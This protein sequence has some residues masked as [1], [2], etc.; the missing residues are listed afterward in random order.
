MS[1]NFPGVTN[2]DDAVQLPV[3]VLTFNRQTLGCIAHSSS[4]TAQTTPHRVDMHPGNA[5]NKIKDR[6]RQVQLPTDSMLT[7][8]YQC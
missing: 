6:F 5:Y 2:A 7:T 1:K 3:H 8:L 4:T